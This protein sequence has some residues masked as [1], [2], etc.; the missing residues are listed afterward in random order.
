MGDHSTDRLLD[1]EVK[2]LKIEGEAHLKHLDEAKRRYGKVLERA[3]Q[4][5]GLSKKEAAAAIQCDPGQLGRWF[6][7]DENPQAWRFHAHPTLGGALLEAQAEA[8]EREHG[9]F[10]VV[11]DIRSKRRQA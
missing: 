10:E 5:A 7:G 6:S 11:T 2:M 3:V 9:D 8:R 1:V 4:L